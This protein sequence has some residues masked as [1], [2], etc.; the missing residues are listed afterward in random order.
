MAILQFLGFF[1]PFTL[2]DI[3]LRLGLAT[4]NEAAVSI[5]YRVSGVH[6]F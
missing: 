5:S 1:N 6:T 3:W 2:K 4:V